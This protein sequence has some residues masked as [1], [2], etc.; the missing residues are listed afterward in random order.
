M[1]TL[2]A[3]SQPPIRPAPL[4]ARPHPGLSL[5]EAPRRGRSS[6]FQR[7][8]AVLYR[9]RWFL[10]LPLALG[11]AGGLWAARHVRPEYVARSTIWIDAQPPREGERGSGPLRSAD[12]LQSRAW[13]ELLRSFTVLDPVV[14]R[15]RLYLTYSEPADSVVFANFAVAEKFRPGDYRL[16]VNPGGRTFRLATRAGL[17]LQRGRVGEAV[18]APAGFSWHPAPAVLRRRRDID[19]TVETPRDAAVRLQKRLV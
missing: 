11:V 1:Q 16:S 14:R 17:T 6:A 2:P 8:R 15:E 7:L 18:G 3:P 13:V 5:D 12:L 10:P 9:A 19:F 4:P